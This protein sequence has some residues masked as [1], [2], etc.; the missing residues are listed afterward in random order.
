MALPCLDDRISHGLVAMFKPS[1]PDVFFA[2]IFDIE[3][4][5]RLV[6][7]NS[8]SGATSLQTHFQADV[9]IPLDKHRKVEFLEYAK[10]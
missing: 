6:G 5:T 10:Y 1:L 8:H 7:E 3:D 2:T 9:S 4:G